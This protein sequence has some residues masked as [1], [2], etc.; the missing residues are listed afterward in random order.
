VVVPAWFTILFAIVGLV[1]SVFYAVN[2]YTIFGASK[3]AETVSQIH[4]FWFNFLGSLLGWAVLWFLVRKA[5]DCVLI[6]C[7][8]N[9][10]PSDALVIVFVF[11]CVTGHLPMATAEVIRGLSLLASKILDLLPKPPAH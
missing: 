9:F 6:G 11:V 2:A 10:H 8:G 7:P 3:P 5:W 1:A 4:Q